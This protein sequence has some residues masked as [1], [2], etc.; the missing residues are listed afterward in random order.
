MQSASN[1]SNKVVSDFKPVGYGKVGDIPPDMDSG[2]FVFKL[3]KVSV[4][5]TK[6][7]QWPM[8]VLEWKGKKCLEGQGERNIGASVT[9]FIVFF[10][11]GERKGN[12]SRRQLDALLTAAG[13]DKTLV[14]EKI[15]N[16]ADFDELS[17]A[18]KGLQ[19][20]AWVTQEK[21]K[22]TGEVRCSIKYTEPKGGLNLSSADDDEDD[23]G[24]DDDAPPARPA[25]KAAAN[26]RR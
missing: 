14:P 23:D 15:E 24:D 13:I 1:G 22:S 3:D 21:D 8:L 26:K 4:R 25:K 2:K 5:P 12:M 11:E 16:K 20:D 9:D 6:K 18:L 7:D 10:P 17:A 19:L